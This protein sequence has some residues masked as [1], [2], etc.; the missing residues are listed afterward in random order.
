MGALPHLQGCGKEDK[1]AKGGGE[2]KKA[3][4]PTGS[5]GAGPAAGAGAG[6]AATTTTAE[7]NQ[8]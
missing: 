7:R 6:A 8:E 1:C 5:A 4:S 2:V 3:G